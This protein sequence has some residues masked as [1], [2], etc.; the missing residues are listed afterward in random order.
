MLQREIWYCK[1]LVLKL[2]N[3]HYLKKGCHTDISPS[4]DFVKIFVTNKFI[5][6]PLEK[7]FYLENL[8]YEVLGT[9]S[10]WQK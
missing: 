2:Y 8:F 3:L 4:D 10:K 5:F 6:L 7:R 1:C 9:K